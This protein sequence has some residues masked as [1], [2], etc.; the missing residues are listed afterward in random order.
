[1]VQRRLLQFILSLSQALVNDGIGSFT[2]QHNRAIFSPRDGRH[3]FTRAIK[4]HLVNASETH[5][6]DFQYFEFDEITKHVNRHLVLHAI[7]KCEPDIFCRRNQRGF[8]G[9]LRLIDDIKVVVFVGIF[10]QNGMTYC[11]MRKKFLNLS[12]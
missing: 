6:N 12:S 9:R 10:G 11:K 3:A 2:V 7:D 5:F 1:M 4:L 8:I